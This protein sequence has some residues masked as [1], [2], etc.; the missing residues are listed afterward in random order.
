MQIIDNIAQWQALRKTIDGGIHLGFVPTM[1][2]LHIGHLSLIQAS[3]QENDQTIVSLFVNPTQFNN[4]DDFIHYPRT[5]ENDLQQLR[6]AKVDYCLIPTEEAMYPEGYRYHIEENKLAQILEGSYRPGH[7]NGVLTVVMKLLQL[8]R[9]NNAYFG[10]KDY[11][12]FELIRNMAAAFFLDI[13]IK[14]CPTIREKSG[15][16]YSSRNNR[17]SPS[18]RTQAEAFA[19]LFHQEKPC[20]EIKKQLEERGIEVDYLEEYSGR[21][22]AAVY[23]GKIRLIDNY[24]ID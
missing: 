8:V 21:R 5:L 16:A 17:L 2:N 3:Q 11:Q 15:L 14:S 22:F 6:E 24:R 20:D 13:Q 7:F 9:P 1:G 12:Q 18:E 19:Q 4:K 10:E 23:I